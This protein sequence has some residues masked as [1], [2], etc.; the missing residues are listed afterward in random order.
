MALCARAK[1]FQGFHVYYIVAQKKPTPK[2]SDVVGARV[3]VRS[4]QCIHLINL[5]FRV[6]CALLIAELGKRLGFL[7]KKC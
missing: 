5:Y 1:A 6:L 4:L 2:K 7:T 3:N